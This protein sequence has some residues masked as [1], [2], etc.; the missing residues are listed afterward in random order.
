MTNYCQRCIYPDTKPGLSLNEDG[1][2][3]GCLAQES[4]RQIDWAARG[5]ELEALASRFRRSDGK[6][7]CLIP[8]SGGKDSTCQVYHARR[9]G[10]NPLCVSVAPQ[11]ET[12]IGEKNL[13]NLQSVFRIEIVVLKP[14]RQ[15]SIALTRHGMKKNAWPN[16]AQ[17]KMIY[18]WPLQEAIRRDIP[19]VFMGENH[20]FEKGGKDLGQGPNAAKQMLHSLDGELDFQEFSDAGISRDKLNSYTSPHGE[21]EVRWLGYY[22]DWDS[23]EIY[24]LAEREGFQAMSEPFEGMIEGYSGIDDSVSPINMWLKFIKFGFGAVTEAAF[25][26]ISYGRMSR[27][28]AV[29]LVN[30]KEGILDPRCKSAWLDYTGMSEAEFNLIVDQFA[31]HELVHKINGQ[32]RLRQPVT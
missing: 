12:A 3:S 19:L 25:N 10:L 16:W 17:D 11:S 26:H 32:W 27:G 9:I 30:E 29:N 20:D 31:N 4:K 14:E 22:I 28:E 7:D 1:I 23:Y 24:K 18:S 15:T 21:M 13:A 8:I 6:Y 5:D 2:C